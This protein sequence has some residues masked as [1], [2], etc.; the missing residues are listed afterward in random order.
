MP[1]TL[2]LLQV[3]PCMPLPGMVPGTW[4]GFLAPPWALVGTGA[5]S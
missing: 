3:G 1:V 5:C 4:Q 2:H